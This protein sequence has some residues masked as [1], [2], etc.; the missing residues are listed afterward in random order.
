MSAVTVDEVQKAMPR[1]LTK[2]EEFLVGFAPPGADAAEVVEQLL[3]RS[4]LLILEEILGRKLDAGEHAHALQ[5]FEDGVPVGVV[6][7][8]L[9]QRKLAATQKPPQST[10]STS[11]STPFGRR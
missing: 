10:A 6:A 5:S 11:T 2:Y 1:P 9:E 3:K 8:Q 7:K 4:Y